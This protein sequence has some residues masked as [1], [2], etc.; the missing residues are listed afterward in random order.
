MTS[1]ATL[2]VREAIDAALGNNLT[3]KSADAEWRARKRESDRAFNMLYPT[4]SVSATALKSNEVSPFL[5]GVAADGSSE[6]V[7]PKRENLALGLTVQE[8]FSPVSLGL[9]KEASL[10]RRKSE[11]DREMAKRE[12]VAAV[13]KGFYQ[14]ITQ[15]E[16]VS[17]TRARLENAEEELRQAK[18]AYDLGQGTELNYRYAKAA[19]EAIEPELRAM[20][21]ARAM[22]LTRFQ[23]L[24]GIDARADLALVGSL[25]DETPARA[26]TLPSA[27][28]RF[29]VAESALAVARA[30]NALRVQNLALFPA[31][32]A[33]YSADPSINGPKASTVLDG[34]NW[35]QSTGAL[36]VT[37]SW[38]LSGLLPGSDIRNKRAE[39][40]ERISLAEEVATEAA[41]NA[42]HD[43]ED[44]RALMRDSLEK[45]QSLG[46]VVS[47]LARAYELTGASYR[48]GV[49]RYLDVQAAELALRNARIEL[50]GE[51]LN[52]VGLSCDRE[53]RYLG[54]E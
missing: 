49:G 27:A 6:Y 46:N 3:V 54:Q 9:M 19:A 38:T 30:R 5:V 17:L 40:R 14:L 53:A 26:E 31:I 15:E 32:V 29:D 51:R 41:R 37:L 20:E 39:L 43:A 28:S 16:T 25:D 47:D 23:E 8:I 7:L 44:Q 48:A 34:D 12:T 13:K 22:A 10:E 11:L 24:I 1:P 18:V 35:G 4:L 36:S 33:Q 50:L 42:R 2:T 45:I 21:T 52:L